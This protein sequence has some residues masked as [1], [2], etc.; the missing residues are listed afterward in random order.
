M[1]EAR[2]ATLPALR[3]IRAF[4]GLRG[5]AALAV[6]V[7]HFTPGRAVATMADRAV[8]RCCTMVDLFFVLSGFVMAL[9]YGGLFA[10]RITAAGLR[11]FLIRRVARI[12]PLYLAVTL[13]IAVLVASGHS[14]R[15]PRAGLPPIALAN[16]AMVQSWIGLPSL[17]FPTWSISTEWAAY[18]VFPLLVPLLLR[19]VPLA[20]AIPFGALAAFAT[21]LVYCDPHL[22]PMTIGR[23]GNGGTNG[24]IGA[25]L[26][27]LADF[28]LGILVFRLAST[29]TG[30]R[31]A[32]S[33][34]SAVP[35]AVAIVLLFVSPPAP[36][37]TALIVL[38]FPALLL[39]VAADRG[40]LARL[41]ASGT[42][43][44]LGAW[45]Y[46]IYLL[47]PGLIG[48]RTRLAVLLGRHAVPHPGVFA[49]IGTIV[50]LLPIAALVH[51]LFEVPMRRVVR[52][53][54]ELTRLRP[55]RMPP[56]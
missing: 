40:P 47:H 5:F 17:D 31:I 11:V 44:R 26:Q 14:D 23:G 8:D 52:D 24:A 33:G 21:A 3:N 36:V 28:T 46:A 20:R 53:R 38:L 51:Q 49:S 18:L 55:A 56:V 41:F 10:R 4:D 35:I 39:S 30:A 45:S 16:V 48:P 1:T 2:A 34:W 6:V 50:V 12:Y 15:A 7:Y 25:M 54:L 27:C 9:S 32:A 37:L 29:R 43:Q 19:E 13:G 42:G 22:S